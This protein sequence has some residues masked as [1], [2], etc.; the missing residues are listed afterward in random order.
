MMAERTVGGPGSALQL[1]RF[2][3][4]VEGQDDGLLGTRG[5]G[6][7]GCNL[8][9][10]AGSTRPAALCSPRWILPIPSSERGRIKLL[11]IVLYGALAIAAPAFDRSQLRWLEDYAQAI[12][13]GGLLLDLLA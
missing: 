4:V 3:E 10:S 11:D 9:P 2:A 6:R 7:D 1:A 12:S 5:G 13:S 8:S